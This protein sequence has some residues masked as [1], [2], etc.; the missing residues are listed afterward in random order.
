[1]YKIAVC[2]DE[3]IIRD[4]ICRLCSDILTEKHMEHSLTTFRNAEEFEH[5]LQMRNSFDLVI[6]DIELG[7][8]DGIS[9]ARDLR[10]QEN[11]ISIVFV[12]AHEIYLRDGYGVQ[13]VHFLIKPVER[14]ALD[15]ALSADIRLHHHNMPHINVRSGSKILPVCID[16]IIYVEVMDHI[17]HIHTPEGDIPSR[18][19]LTLFMNSLPAEDFC[20][21]HNSFTVNLRYIR[22]I[23]HSSVSLSNNVTLPI[24]RKYYDSFQKSFIRYINCV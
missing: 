16:D 7:G 19:T 12:S 11:Q 3:S 8:K 20:R 5:S 9:L 1:M 13:P 6:L 4:D 18:S 23:S 21:C 15:E 14:S 22:N 10:K 2:E 24:G 17:L